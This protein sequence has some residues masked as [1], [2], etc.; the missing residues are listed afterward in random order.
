MAQD[1][2]INGATHLGVKYTDSPK[3]DG[4]GDARFYDA[5]ETTATAA[6]IRTGYSAIIADGETP[7]AMPEKTASDIT[8]N[9]RTA[10]IPEGHYDGTTKQVVS[11]TVDLKAEYVLAGHS[12]F[13]NNLNKI[14]GT[15]TVPV[16]TYNSS[17]KVLRIS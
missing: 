13:D 6:Q 1:I 11:E 7:G 17:T 12:G 16:V 10:T 5:S 15:A 2:K 8:I 4:S 3:A 14:P 9:G